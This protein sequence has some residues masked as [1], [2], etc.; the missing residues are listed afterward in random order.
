MKEKMDLKVSGS[1]RI[2]GGEYGDVSVSGSLIVNGGLKCENLHCSGSTKIADAIECT[3][4]LHSSGSL[5]IGTDASMAEGKF[6]GSFSCGGDLS[7]TEE[8]GVSGMCSVGGSAQVGQAHISGALDVGSCLK[9]HSVHCSGKL[10]VPQDV[11]AEEFSSSGVLNIEGLLNSEEVELEISSPCHVGDIGGG[12]I[13][14]KKRRRGVSLG[15][16]RSRLVVE[17]VEGDE[18]YLEATHAETVRG[19]KV[20]IGKDCQIACVEYSERLTVDGGVVEQQVKI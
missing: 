2:P 13:T 18:I 1:S 5:S 3:E 11:E 4:E 7:C 20:H 9:A 8:L 14:V 6:S 12:S 15:A 17:T 16:G 10:N 19:K